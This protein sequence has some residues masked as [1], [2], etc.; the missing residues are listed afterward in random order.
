MNMFYFSMNPY[1]SS[2]HG[3]ADDARELP[4]SA[5]PVLKRP[6]N[7][8]LAEK[9]ARLLQSIGMP[10]CLRGTRYLQTGILLA[11][12]RPELIRNLSQKLYPA[13]AELHHTR[14]QC[15]EKNIRHAIETAWLRGNSVQ[16]EALFCCTDPDKGKPTNAQFLSLLF[17]TLS[18]QCGETLL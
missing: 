1:H 4:V 9:T 14:P 13:I 3:V 2:L 5:L 7:R 18:P 16:L 12:Q 17:E 10:S 8:E 6:W 11:K 15:V